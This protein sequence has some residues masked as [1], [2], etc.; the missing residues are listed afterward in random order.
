MP[1]KLFVGPFVGPGFGGRWLAA[2]A[3]Q[4]Y[5][6]ANKNTV[7]PARLDDNSESNYQPAQNHKSGTCSCCVSGC[8]C[9][10]ACRC[11]PFHF[12]FKTSAFL[13][14]ELRRLWQHVETWNTGN[15]DQLAS[16]PELELQK[17]VQFKL[18]GQNSSPQQHSG[19]YCQCWDAVLHRQV[20]WSKGPGWL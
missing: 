18:A 3:P 6:S 7:T 11:R 15:G 5:C 14:L 17:Q 2:Q 10:H 1:V 9:T 13:K 19:L 16:E 4:S 12:K 8:Q 20:E